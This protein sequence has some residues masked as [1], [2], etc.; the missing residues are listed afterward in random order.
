LVSAAISATHSL[1]R[2]RD[3]RQTPLSFMSSG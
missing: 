3:I 2:A 1:R